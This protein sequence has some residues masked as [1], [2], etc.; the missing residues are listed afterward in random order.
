MS[1]KSIGSAITNSGGITQ[2][3]NLLTM[4]GRTGSMSNLTA[5]SIVI[6]TFSKMGEMTA[7]MGAMEKVSTTLS[8]IGKNLGGLTIAGNA[9][10]GLSQESAFAILSLQNLSFEEAKVA[11]A[12]YGLSGAE[13]ETAA[14]TVAA[15][16][17]AAGASGGFSALAAGVLSAAKAFATFLITNP[18]GW[19][20]IAGAALLAWTKHIENH[21]R[22]MREASQ[23]ADDYAQKSKETYEKEV[24]ET[25]SLNDLIDKY[26][27]LKRQYE[28]GG[29]LDSGLRQQILDVQSQIT[30]MVGS[31]AENL[32]LVNGK[33][34]EELGKL[35]DI[36]KEQA[37][38]E[39]ESANAAYKAAVDASEKAVSIGLKG[40]SLAFKD[41]EIYDYV[42][43]ITQAER[44][45]FYESG[46]NA[47]FENW[48]NGKFGLNFDN[49]FAKGLAD[50]FDFDIS[51]AEGRVE[52]ISS[53]MAKLKEAMPDSYFNSDLYA[54]LQV[55]KEHYQ[56]YV[57]AVADSAKSLIDATVKQ[58]YYSDALDKSAV[59]DAQS[60]ETY[61]KTWID[62]V[63]NDDMIKQRLADGVIS[64]SDVEEQV[65]YYIST[66]SGLSDFYIDWM[67]QFDEA[68]V[69]RNDKVKEAFSLTKEA[70]ALTEWYESLPEGDKELV[71][72]I[73]LSN[74]DEE[75]QKTIDALA[76]MSEGGSVDLNLRPVIDTKILKDA[77]WKDAGEGAATVF[78]STFA[79]QAAENN[80]DGGIAMNFTP[81][82]ADE[83]GDFVGVLT[84]EELED[85]ATEVIN[86]YERTGIL[87]DDKG[88]KVGA[89]FD[90]KDAI[91]KASA[92]AE[93]IHDA[94]AKIYTTP[95][96]KNMSVDSYVEALE[97]AKEETVNAAT[98]VSESWKGTLEDFD[99]LWGDDSQFKEGVDDYTEQLDTLKE[100]ID[101]FDKGELDIS[102]IVSLRK[103][104]KDLSKYSNK[105]LDKGLKKVYKDLLGLGDATD[106][107]TGL[108]GLF[109]DQ[110]EEL[111][112]RSPET[113]DALRS[114]RDEYANLY[115]LDRVEIDPLQSVRASL[116]DTKQL[117]T[118]LS[119]VASNGYLSEETIQELVK[120]NSGYKSVLQQT[121]AGMV[122]DTQEAT[123]LAQ[124][125]NE[126][127]LEIAEAN[128]Y[129]AELSYKKNYDEMVELAG[130]AEKLK[131]ILDSGVGDARI[132]ELNE[133]NTDL[134]DDIAEWESLA[135]EIRGTMSLL[136]Q[137]QDAQKTSNL[138]D[139]YEQVKSGLKGAD[140]LY[141]Q[142]W[143]GRDDFTSF[144]KLLAR[145]GATEAEAVEQ[146]EANRE[147]FKR[148]L[149]TDTAEEGILNFWKDATELTNEA[150]EAFL[151]YDQEAD[152]FEFNID[153]M[154]EFADAMGVNTEMAEYFLLAL[155]DL[156]YLDIDLSMIGDS[157]KESVESMDLSSDTAVADMEHLIDRMGDLES[158]GVDCSES[159]PSIAS[160]LSQLQ[161]AGV[162]IDPL[163]SKL[164]ELGYSLE[165]DEETKEF[166]FVAD[167]SDVQEKKESA[168]EEIT[169]EVKQEVDDSEVQAAKE[170]ARETITQKVQQVVEN[171][172]E[173][174]ANFFGGGKT[175]ETATTTS[176]NVEVT[177]TQTPDP[178]VI[179]TFAD[180]IEIKQDG[181]VE[182]KTDK[183]VYSV[184]FNQD[185]TV[186]VKTDKEEYTVPIKQDGTVEV[187]T[188]KETYNIKFNQDGTIEIKTD[189]DEYTVPFKQD[190]TVEIKTDKEIY[191]IKFNQDGTVTVKT[192][193]DEYTVPI[194]QDGTI[195]VK[196]D[197]DVY[198]VKFNQDG[199]VT[200][201]TDKEEYTV[202]VKQEGTTDVTLTESEKS[203]DV[204]ANPETVD[205]DV[206]ADGDVSPTINEMQKYADENPINVSVN[207]N[208]YGGGF[209]GEGYE[210][211]EG[212]AT[213][214]E[215]ESSG[216]TEIPATLVVDDVDTSNAP[217][218]TQ[219]E[220]ELHVTKA[221]NPE[222]LPDPVEMEGKVTEVE[223]P[224]PETE[225]VILDADNSPL[226]ETVVESESELDGLAEKETEPN[227]EADNTEAEGEINETSADLDTL[228]AKTS[229]PGISANDQA[230][231]TISSVSSA[232]DA[233]DGKTA[234]TTIRNVTINETRNETSPANGTFS[235]GGHGFASGT[236]NAFVRGANVAIGKNQ[237]ALVNELGNAL[238]EYKFI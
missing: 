110:I 38:Q 175:E 72:S 228:G 29:E 63:K 111:D 96:A 22:A 19:L 35:G 157:F 53:M 24:E 197:K 128:K 60:L 135:A 133:L 14:S 108:M 109:N 141:E 158:K 10:K 77:G 154:N 217:T 104:F 221:E 32:D 83:N 168:E 106:D 181:T 117:A 169:E 132:F 185:G 30:D 47:L 144:A 190:G 233:L 120:T 118:A 205:V 211:P 40:Q 2:F 207:S 167:D 27:E 48:G 150:G 216:N 145:N 231:G 134:S 80:E 215:P 178:L 4:L 193:K 234:T 166:K 1:L 210:T 31:Q 93:S 58:Q 232:L 9:L 112:K 15:G 101:K 191:S 62:L 97:G 227:I 114:I 236:V 55:A 99:T 214:E 105:D 59:K 152:E 220:G 170:R 200:I 17:A 73:V 218:D 45:A 204:S 92:I 196:T 21:N 16:S 223:I 34:D 41:K 37:N 71:Y 235:G 5:V 6:S 43:K 192:D 54:G 129:A 212:E 102:D 75:R 46:Y 237:T 238:A 153:S 49:D 206:N 159:L 122:I 165:F 33:L 139:A 143:L 174:V 202:P 187:K 12:A 91:S 94:Q 160:A 119:E 171:V 182:I 66:L 85:Y 195:E 183:E 95:E 88:L 100:A 39:K 84:P 26:K 146:Y 213:P 155:K 131:E 65:D 148:Y 208:P 189:K 198:S 140:E 11:L 36:A 76:K 222:T 224:E 177:V 173:K 138:G 199:T 219:V 78:T 151:T 176:Q 51:T 184:K 125:Q 188:D 64:E 229:T 121:A 86:E 113:A 194:K 163:I 23:A 172:R 28:A 90:G 89:T 180:P 13:L 56:G 136:Q 18:V 25:Q 69:E 57:D 230:S 130:G 87:K 50:T 123:K 209:M 149:E 74:T 137:Y 124:A 67:N 107:S 82:I 162:N 201:K 42:G 126:L 127:N 68:T 225:P 8:S 70:D 161:E 61:R 115:N 164:N 81:I 179:N 3:T 156:G 7:G 226:Q 116:A 44:D 203:I 186:T 142:G 103:E 52:A 98:I 147:R 20:L 79:N